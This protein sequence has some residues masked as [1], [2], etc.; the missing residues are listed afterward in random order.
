MF[1]FL[2]LQTGKPGAR[3]ND[4]W[5]YNWI[6]KRFVCTCSVSTGSGLFLAVT[7][8]PPARGWGGAG[9][10]SGEREAVFVGG[11]VS[12]AVPAL[13]AREV[14]SR[15]IRLGPTHT[16]FFHFASDILEICV[17]LPTFVHLAALNKARY[18]RWTDLPFLAS[19][20]GILRIP[21][22]F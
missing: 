8:L 9:S 10:R 1:V 5:S 17:Y 2:I 16:F 14:T 3:I 4:M 21:Y 15:H 13:P 19:F 12:G 6:R 11:A 7:A 18:C 20:H 22:V